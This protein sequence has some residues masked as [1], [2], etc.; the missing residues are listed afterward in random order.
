MEPKD[1]VQPQFDFLPLTVSIETLGGVS[2]PLILRGTPLP[3]KRSQ[4]FSTASDNQPSVE[5]KVLL[6]ERPLAN[7]N[8]TIGSCMLEGIP[9][10]PKGQPQIRVTFEVDRFCSVK[11]EAVETKSRREIGVTLEETV[12]QLNNDV[13]QKL[14]READENREEDKARSVIASAE[15]RVRKDQEQ[16]SVTETT[17]RIEALIADIGLALMGGNKLLIGTKTKELEKL[18]A[19]LAEAERAK[20]FFEFGGLSNIFGTFY[21]PK[22]TTK[23]T[24]RRQRPTRADSKT[25]K[26]ESANSRATVVSPTPTT[27]VVK[28]FLE[29][30]DPELELKRAAAW[31]AIESGRVD[32]LAQASHSMREVLRQLL[33]KLAPAEK[34]IKAPWYR[35]PNSGAPVTRAMRIR[36]A[37][38]GV[39]DVSSESTLSLTKDLAAAV[40]SMYAKLSAESHRGRGATVSA[41]RMYLGACEAVIGLVA[42]Q[43][44]D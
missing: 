35:K 44:H 19:E 15:L 26:S 3:A 33:D 21:Q 22:S 1:N 4:T 28:S 37:L 24:Q 29:N 39:S 18:L 16:N 8:M 7:K 34:V 6:G 38:S 36:Y 43:R 17:H 31:E 20:S 11:V 40:D 25:V 30:V 42:S 27:T 12:T 32:G 23:A 2:T 10:A 13:I 5:I 41:T 9:P 14:L